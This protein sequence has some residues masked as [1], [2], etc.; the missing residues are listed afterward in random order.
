MR[1]IKVLIKD[2]GKKPRCVNVS[3]RLENLQKIVGGNIETF[4]CAS[5]ATIICNE[6]GKLQG[7][8]YNCYIC[9]NHFF[10]TII[11]CGVS[12]DEFCDIPIGYSEIKKGFSRLWEEQ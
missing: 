10:G 6:E 5:D 2:P 11:L 8:P 9:G 7:L 1:K 3:D 4:K 12:R